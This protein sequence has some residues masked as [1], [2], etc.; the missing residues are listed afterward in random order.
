MLFSEVLDKSRQA[1]NKVDDARETLS[2]IKQCFGRG[3]DDDDDN[4]VDLLESIYY[5]SYYMCHVLRDYRDF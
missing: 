5:V 2:F 3:D 1:K 4:N